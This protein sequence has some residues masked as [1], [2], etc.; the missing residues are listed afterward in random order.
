MDWTWELVAG[1]YNATTEGPTWDGTGLL[2]SCIPKN[3]ILRYDPEKND[4]TEFR[5]FTNGLNGL[6]FGPDGAL[7][8]CQSLSRRM[9]RFNKD[10]STTPLPWLLDGRYHNRP[11]DVVVDSRG[12]VWFSDP[13]EYGRNVPTRGPQPHPVVDHGSILRYDPSPGGGQAPAL[14][15]VTFDTLNPNGLALSPDEKTL[16]VAETSLEVAGTRELRAY[17]VLED[18]SVGEYR[19]LHDFG[20]G[21]VNGRA[22]G[23]D[24]M[25]VDAEGNILACAGRLGGGPGPMVYVFSPTGRILDTHPIPADR[26]TNCCFGGPTLTELYLTTIGG[27]LFRVK[28]TGHKGFMRYP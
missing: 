5:R 1:P 2:F 18:G 17:P 3:Q 10:G 28:E 24:G 7:Y 9:V 11:N 6:A 25:T 21:D 16:Y 20:V 4:V 27:H 26:P 8:G 19:V 22:R 23:V 13:Y 14:Q 12:R 15:R